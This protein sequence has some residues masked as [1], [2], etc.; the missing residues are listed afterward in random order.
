MMQI[1][2]ENISLQNIS[3][4]DVVAYLKNTGW[5]QTS[6]PNQ[7]FLLFLKVPLENGNQP[8]KLAIPKNDEFIDT[9]IR[10]ATAVNV[11]ANIEEVPPATIIHNITHLYRD[12]LKL[13][14]L[15]SEQARIPV[16]TAENIIAGLHNVLS[17]AAS[18]EEQNNPF[19]THMLPVGR[20]K[21][22]NFRFGH[23][24]QGSFGFAIESFLPYKQ[25]SSSSFDDLLSHAPER[26]ILER[27]VRGFVITQQALKLDDVSFMVNNYHRGLNANIYEVLNKI[28]EQSRRSGISLEYSIDWSPIMKPADDIAAFQSLRMD[29]NVYDFFARAAREL[30]KDE[31]IAGTPRT[32]QGR[33]TNLKSEYAPIEEDGK[34]RTMTVTYFDAQEKPRKIPVVLSQPDYIQACNAHRDGNVI[35]VTGTLKKKVGGNWVLEEVKDFVVYEYHPAQET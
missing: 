17:Y 35:A 5:E 11:L 1:T 10:L 20:R 32:I 3:V 21:T 18:L 2:P 7:N 27:I 19:F 16:Q 13:R 9:P 33:I 4:Q 15:M 29:S 23:T 12:V 25:F 24:F 6:H 31:E 30:R 22:E 28:T 34:K 26:K 8:I 14:L